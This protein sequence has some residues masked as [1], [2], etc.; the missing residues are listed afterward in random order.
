M[1]NRTL[2]FF[3]QGYG[4]EAPIVTATIDGTTVFV[5]PVANFTDTAPPQIFVPADYEYLFSAEIPFN[6]ANAN[7]TMNVSFTGATA[8]VLGEVLINYA[9]QVV[10]NSVVSSS[11]AS[12][13]LESYPAGDCRT[14]VTIDGVSQTTPDPRP[15]GLEGDWTWQI[16]EGNVLSYTLLVNSGLE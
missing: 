14:N 12:G 10:A 16:A 9:P 6:S 15:T 11:G 1:P 8:L 3:G 13:F 4:P 5:G 2:Q 7:L